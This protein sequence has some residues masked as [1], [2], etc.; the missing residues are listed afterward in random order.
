[1]EFKKLLFALVVLCPMAHAGEPTVGVASQL[2]S[3][4]T[5]AGLA[6]S[7]ATP[8]D[9]VVSTSPAYR[10]VAVENIDTAANLWCS[11]NSGVTSSAGGLQ[12]WKILGTGDK[13]DPQANGFKWN[14]ED[15]KV[16]LDEAELGP[17]EE[18]LLSVSEK[19][20]TQVE[21]KKAKI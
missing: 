16:T 12:G 11:D 14:S 2:S 8:T 18:T 3:T 20:F 21:G 17:F 5:C 19:A 10:Y 13:G 9:V 1:M 7:N 4:N 6:I 15:G